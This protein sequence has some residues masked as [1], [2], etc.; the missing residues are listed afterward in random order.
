ML[1]NALPRL[2]P[3]MAFILDF[4]IGGALVVEQY[5]DWPCYV[6]MLS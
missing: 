4:S 5:S 3:M 1:G 2:V 6:G